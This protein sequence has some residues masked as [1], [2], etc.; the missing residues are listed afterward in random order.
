MA[1]KVLPMTQASHASCNPSSGDEPR[2]ARPDERLLRISDVT[3]IVSVNRATW[4][5]WVRN[6]LAPQ[7]IRFGGS[8]FW[9]L[10]SVRKFVQEV[11]DGDIAEP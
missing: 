5:R 6:G 1:S 11:I 10:T 9:T 3:Q 4:Y 2:L 8:T 7:P